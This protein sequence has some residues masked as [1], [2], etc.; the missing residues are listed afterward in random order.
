MFLHNVILF[1][2]NINDLLE[3]SNRNLLK[4][5]NRVKE[6]VAP[7][8]SKEILTKIWN[9]ASAYLLKINSMANTISTAIEK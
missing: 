2:L 3:V 8:L 7:E 1:E 6:V 4:V 5:S 9:R